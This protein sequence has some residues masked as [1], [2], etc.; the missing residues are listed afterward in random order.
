MPAEMPD[1]VAAERRAEQLRDNH[2]RAEEALDFGALLQG[3]EL[4]D[5]D[6]RQRHQAA[7]AD[8]LDGPAG[9]QHRHGLGEP[10][11]Q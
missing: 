9:E 2:E 3:E 8:A 4:A 10:A 1:D 6:E 11:D 7:R 5:N